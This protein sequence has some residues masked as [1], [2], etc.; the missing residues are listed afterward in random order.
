MDRLGPLSG[1]G[2]ENAPIRMGEKDEIALTA[3]FLTTNAAKYI[4]GETI[5]VDGGTWMY[6]ETLPREIYRRSIRSAKL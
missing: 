5:V 1:S 4:N 2:M 3:V 6:R